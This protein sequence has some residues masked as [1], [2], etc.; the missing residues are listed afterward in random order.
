MTFPYDEIRQPD[1]DYFPTWESVRQ[2]GFDNDQIWSVCEYEGLHQSTFS[3]AHPINHFVNRLG[4]IAT[5]QRRS[6]DSEY[7]EET[8]KMD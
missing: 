6:N 1:G 7:Y 5:V 8:I 2:A 3:Y 4:F